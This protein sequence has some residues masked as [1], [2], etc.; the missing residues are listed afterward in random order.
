[1]REA[2]IYGDL[3]GRPALPPMDMPFANTQASCVTCTNARLDCALLGLLNLCSFS[4]VDCTTCGLHDMQILQ[5]HITPPRRSLLGSMLED[6]FSPEPSDFYAADAEEEEVD[7][8][9][10]DD[11]DDDDDYSGMTMSMVRVKMS[12]CL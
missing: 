10:D 4:G 11:T 8:N 7:D 6:I 5:S 12:N 3:L 9:D 2:C 1:M